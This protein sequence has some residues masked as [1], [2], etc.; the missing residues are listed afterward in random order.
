MPVHSDLLRFTSKGLYCPAADV[1]LDPWRPVERA[2]ISHGHADHARAG[3]KHY[4][5]HPHTVSI[6]QHRL[7]DNSYE[8]MEYGEH[9]LINGLR[10]SFHPAGHILGSCQIRIEHQGQVAVFSGDYKL[11]DDGISGSYEPVPCH[12]LITECTFGLPIYR[13]PE[14]QTQTDELNAWVNQ[15]KADGKSSILLA[16]SLGKAQ[17]LLH[18][19]K[20]QQDIHIHGA[21]HHMTE[22]YRQAGVD[23]PQTIY[24]SGKE[25]VKE[26]VVVICPPATLGTTW[27][28]KFRPLRTA[29][30]SG[31]MN[32]RGPRRRRAVDKGLVISDHMDWQGLQ[33]VMQECQP[34][35][36]IC[37]HGYNDIFADYLNSMGIEAAA[38]QTE[39]ETETA[40]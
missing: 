17:R 38:Q 16:Y 6:M 21:I 36:V 13:W 24:P 34:E 30:A 18:M 1:Y 22:V 20:T 11:Q 19:L 14:I 39:F 2:I 4:L 12:Q 37:T 28:N 27:L 7:G 33:T 8:A 9:R 31:W 40:E 3:H 23:L 10:F 32:L 35:K 29:M 15:N 5:A 25:K 26:P